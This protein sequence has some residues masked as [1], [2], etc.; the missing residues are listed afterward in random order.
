MPKLKLETIQV[1]L[2]RETEAEV[3][4]LANDAGL[5][6][7]QVIALALAADMRRRNRENGTRAQRDELL[8]FAKEVAMGAYKPK[9]LKARALAVIASVQPNR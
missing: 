7:E 1:R 3:R 6:P 8:V 9:E 5:K 2:T 4:A